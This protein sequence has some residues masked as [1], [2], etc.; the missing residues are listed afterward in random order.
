[1]TLCPRCTHIDFENGALWALSSVEQ[2]TASA[3]RGCA[4]CVFFLGAVQRMQLEGGLEAS[5]QLLLQR[6]PGKWNCVDLNLVD[7]A[8]LGYK[9]HVPLR[10][11][12]AYGVCLQVG[13]GGCAMVANLR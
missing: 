6:L 10:L 9:S 11:C 4:G 3:A 13:D 12:S 7:A 1:M 5:M 8:T 2:T